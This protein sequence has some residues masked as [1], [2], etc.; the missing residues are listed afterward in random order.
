MSVQLEILT[1]TPNI[2][3]KTD[4]RY[5]ILIQIIAKG[6]NIENASITSSITGGNLNPT[7]G[8][9]DING[10]FKTTFSSTVAGTYTAIFT[11][12]KSPLVSATLTIPITVEATKADDTERNEEFLIGVRSVR[13]TILNYIKQELDNDIDLYPSTGAS[14]PPV[15]LNAFSYTTRDFPQIIVSG[16][17]LIPR[18]TSI[19]DNVIGWNEY[20]DGEWYKTNG[21]LHDLT[22]TLTVIAEDKKTQENLL[23]KVT[24]I[25]WQKKMLN[26]L[27]GD[28]W[29]IN[30]NA[31]NEVT[32]PWGAK[33]LYAGSITLT[34][35]TQWFVKEKYKNIIEELDY[36]MTTI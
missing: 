14:N 31:G 6:I 18:R 9:T 1:K 28:I 12:A 5:E 29:V 17:T 27:E 26:F 21:G 3:L 24:M 32:Q 15:Y 25:I 23:D 10:F 16:G 19:G 30:I 34:L 35:V 11:A 7:S 2:Y 20:E 22:V 33:L 8:L 36:T 13:Q 4:E